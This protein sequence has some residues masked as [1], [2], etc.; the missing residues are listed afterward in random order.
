MHVCRDHVIGRGYK[1]FPLDVTI[2]WYSKIVLRS[3]SWCSFLPLQKAAKIKQ[4]LT[5]SERGH[6]RNEKLILDD[7][8]LEVLLFYLAASKPVALETSQ[9]VKRTK[10]FRLSRDFQDGELNSN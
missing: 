10:N 5:K 9:M 2:K 8:L 7:K 6:S 3:K 1:K 4:V